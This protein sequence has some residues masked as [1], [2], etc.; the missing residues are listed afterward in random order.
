VLYYPL[1]GMDFEP[2]D[3]SYTVLYK[4]FTTLKYPPEAF[5]YA[6]LSGYDFPAETTIFDVY[7][8][9]NVSG[10]FN[11]TMQQNI[12]LQYEVPGWSNVFTTFNSLQYFRYVALNFGYGGLFR[13]V[14][15]TDMINGD[16]YMDETLGRYYKTPVYKGGDKD[17]NLVLAIDKP[18]STFPFNHP[19][20][21]FTGEDNPEMTRSIAVWNNLPYANVRC[22]EYIDIN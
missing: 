6:A 22:N 21:I 18:V 17:L 20:T 7:Q 14:T 2:I 8:G 10:L 15:P 5:Y 9:F 1:P 11:P 4:N 19:V 13:Q 16:V 12:W 3:S